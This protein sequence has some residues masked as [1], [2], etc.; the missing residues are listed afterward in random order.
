MAQ[1]FKIVSR[2]GE[3]AGKSGWLARL[4]A[5]ARRR[6]ARVDHL[7]ERMLRDIGL[8]EGTFRRPKDAPEMALSGSGGQQ[9]GLYRHVPGQRPKRRQTRASS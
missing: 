6:A 4:L 7:S 5:R 3:S 2:H 8:D 1:S 9:F